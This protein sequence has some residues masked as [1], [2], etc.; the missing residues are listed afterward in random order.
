MSEGVVIQFIRGCVDVLRGKVFPRS[1]TITGKFAYFGCSAHVTKFYT[2]F[3]SETALD[4]KKA[5][6][7]KSPWVKTKKKPG[8]KK[9]NKVKV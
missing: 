1:R 3:N 8:L 6:Q 2:E 5:K 4:L 9:A 7:V